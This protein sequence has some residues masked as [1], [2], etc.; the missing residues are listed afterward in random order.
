MLYA[1]YSIGCS[2][3]FHRHH[4]P[5]L[6]RCQALFLWQLCNFLGAAGQT[7]YDLNFRGA[8]THAECPEKDIIKATGG[9]KICCKDDTC[10][11]DIPTLW[12]EKLPADI[13]AFYPDGKGFDAKTST[14]PDK[15]T[16]GKTITLAPGTCAYPDKEKW[17]CKTVST[18]TTTCNSMHVQNRG[19][20]QSSHPLL[21]LGCC[22]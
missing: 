16:K 3:I 2:N 4:G 7:V 8:V 22:Q 15:D 14:N 21:R 5:S 11:V 18:H 17:L 12:G 1:Q 6:L 10:L 20:D 13:V 19:V 9:E